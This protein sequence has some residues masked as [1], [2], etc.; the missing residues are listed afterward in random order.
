MKM[1]PILIYTIV[2]SVINFNKSNSMTD[3]MQVE[4]NLPGTS[5]DWKFFKANA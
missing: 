4:A 1:T 2:I 5:D 3:A